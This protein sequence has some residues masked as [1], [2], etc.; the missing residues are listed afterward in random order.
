MEH[1]KILL[2]LAALFFLA[3]CTTSEVEPMSEPEPT[4]VTP[5]LKEVLPEKSTPLPEPTLDDK[6]DISQP[7][8][9]PVDDDSTDTDVATG[10][11]SPAQVD[12]SQVTSQ[13]PE[14]TTP[15]VAPQPGI[16][17]PKAAT[18]HQVSQDLAKRLGMDIADVNTIGVE[19]V[20]WSDSSLGCSAPGMMYLTVITPGYKITLEAAG[21]KY[22]YHT[23]LQGSY[24]LCGE[25]GLPVEP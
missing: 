4:L 5:H 22:T 7:E 24:L 20:D 17:D 12:L 8:P 9:P 21:E 25:N 23:D 15:Q 14:N 6:D 19:E 3:A 18:A 16:P 11:A 13:P 2:S 10:S 1:L